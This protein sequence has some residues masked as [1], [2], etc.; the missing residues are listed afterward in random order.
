MHDRTTGARLKGWF[1][2]RV[3]VINALIAG[4]VL[5]ASALVA[6]NWALLARVRSLD[7]ALAES[8]RA[9]YPSVGLALPRLS[10]LS[11][12]GTLLDLEVGGDGRGTLLFVFSSSCP[13][14][15]ANWPFWERLGRN[16]P[17][18]RYRLVYVNLTDSLRADYRARHYFRPSA[19]IIGTLDPR[20]AVVY[21]LT[22]SPLLLL[23][24]DDGVVSHVWVGRSD[25]SDQADVERVLRIEPTDSRSAS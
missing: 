8:Q 14:C 24:G 21:N 19:P 7:R 16:V 17:D 23:V 5:L 12:E 4:I 18:R 9:R 1:T 6:A 2:Q 15:E 13:L 3:E 10:G 25:E 11:P 22:I 20:H